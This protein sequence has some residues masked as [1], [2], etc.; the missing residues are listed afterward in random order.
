L[1]LVVGEDKKW[2][3]NSL[4]VMVLKRKIGLIFWLAVVGDSLTPS[5][6]PA[7]RAGGFG[8][9]YTAKFLQGF[10]SF[11]GS[12]ERKLIFLLLFNW[13]SCSPFSGTSGN[14]GTHSSSQ[15]N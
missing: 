13:T 12:S 14:P 15:G 6:L 4:P 5:S 2:T 11:V 9:P 10:K 1:D 3:S 8:T 7:P